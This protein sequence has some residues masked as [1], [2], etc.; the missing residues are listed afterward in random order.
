[1]NSSYQHSSRAT[2]IWIALLVTLALLS[3][4]AMRRSLGK[5]MRMN[6]ETTAGN[7]S[8][9]TKPGEEVKVVLEV[10]A[11]TAAASLE[12][13]VLEKQSETVYL[14]TGKTIKIAFDASTPVVMGRTSDVKAG[15]VLHI[16]AK[17]GSDEVLRSEQIVILSG[18][19]KVQE[20]FQEK[21]Q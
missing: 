18:F 10:T 2:R 7:S 21:V 17:M 4:L 8:A 5:A 14:R 12:G 6:A 9:Q 15:A 20:K 1:M 13:N 11:F 16:K 19:V 3:F